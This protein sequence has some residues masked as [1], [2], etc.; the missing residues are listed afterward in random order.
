[1]SDPDAPVVPGITGLTVIGRG[2][3]GIVYRG[4]QEDLSRD[5]AVKVLAT[6]G[7]D[8]KA[9]ESWRREVTAM[10][11]LS[12]HPNI[13]PVYAAGVTEDGLPYLLM[14]YVAAG[15]LHDRV[16]TDGPLGSVEVAGLGARLAGGLAA[17]HAAGVLHRDLKPANVLL[18]QYGEPQLSDFGIAR[19]VD[20]A[21]TT[22]GSVRATIG[23]AAPEVLSGEGATEAADVYGLGATLHAALSGRAPF[24]STDPSEPMVARVGRVLTQPPPDLVPLGVDPDLA[25][26]VDACLAKDPNARPASAREVQR[27]LDALGD[28]AAPPAG[29]APT[30]AAPVIGPSR[31]APEP[32]AVIPPIPPIPPDE[33]AG[34]RPGRGALVALAL[35]VVFALAALGAW[36]LTRDGGDDTAAGD[37]A[38]TT[39]TT[40]TT[41]TT[42]APTEP[43]TTSTEPTTT[44]S[45]TTTS[46]T[47]TSTTSTTTTTTTEPTPL[48]GA[49]T[50]TDL[51]TA[52]AHY[53]ATVRS[54]DLD[55]SWAL[56]SARFQ[57]ESGGRAAYD[58]WWGRT[59][60]SVDV[61]DQPRGDAEAGTTALRLHYVRS[62]GG[63]TTE[64]VV[65]TFVTAGDDGALLIDRYDTAGAR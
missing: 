64:D 40:A 22:T 65:L 17:A 23:Y 37:R 27:R 6:A 19:L 36:A 9:V 26:V 12:N 52:A 21:T 57:E 58:R 16:V 4:R 47:T 35:V 51:E 14:P 18:T 61:L 15:S 11:R 32:T 25:A 7:A 34:P 45:T 38:S 55:A 43:T 53:Y 56:L 31:P 54:G 39:A 60:A 59:I 62:D 63:E 48:V 50:A 3:F 49:P 30:V 8:P 44:T 24:A 42:E 28:G 13:V 41:T 29:D 5:V 46:T 33:P 1:M 2:G 20:A 10:G